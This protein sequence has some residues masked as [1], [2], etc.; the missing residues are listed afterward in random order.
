MEQMNE[1]VKS[2][3]LGYFS[4]INA[5]VYLMDEIINVLKKVDNQINNPL[6]AELEP[7][8]VEW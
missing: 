8:E 3:V 1:Q 5:S 4:M 2:L 6:P 7:V